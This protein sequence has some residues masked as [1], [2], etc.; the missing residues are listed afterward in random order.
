MG[1]AQVQTTARQTRE[2]MGLDQRRPPARAHALRPLAPDRAPLRPDCGSRMTGD[3]HVRFCESRGC[4]SPRL[5]T[6]F[7]EDRDTLG[8]RPCTAGWERAQPAIHITTRGLLHRG[9]QRTAC[10]CM[11]RVRRRRSAL[12]PRSAFAGF[13]FPS[14]VI[15]LTVRWYLRF[16]LS[17]RDV[18]E[19]PRRA[20][21]HRRPR[22]GL[23]AGGA[24][25]PIPG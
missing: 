8:K 19:P 11:R 7:H 14:E 9:R 21:Y 22:H 1:D 3:R 10:S 13:R 17:Y 20:R 5:L 24:I 25:H 6:N 23:S 4:D 16:G 15:V 2:S 18:E 12:P